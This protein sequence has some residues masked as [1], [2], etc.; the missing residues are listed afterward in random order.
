MCQIISQTT[1]L[2]K[3]QK[4]DKRGRGGRFTR[5]KEELLEIQGIH[6]GD[7]NS[8]GFTPKKSDMI[9]SMDKE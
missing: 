5:T 1:R 9:T 4:D 6:P 8:V 3:V 2:E 7:S